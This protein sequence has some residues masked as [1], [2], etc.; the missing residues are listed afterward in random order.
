MT[1]NSGAT[2]YIDYK[3]EAL[4]MLDAK[5]ERVRQNMRSSSKQMITNLWAQLDLSSIYHDWALEGQVVSPE[6]LDLAFDARTITDA[7]NLPLNSSI[8]SHKETLNFASEVATRKKLVITSNL[9]REFHAFF[10]NDAESAK[11]A[12]EEVGVRKVELSARDEQILRAIVESH[13][14]SARPV[15]S[16]A[17][18]RRAALKVSS[19]TV[20]NTMRSLEDAGLIAQPHTSAGR[21]PTDLGYR[22]YVDNLIEPASPSG[23]H[24]AD[25]SMTGSGEA[26]I[27]A[28]RLR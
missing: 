8:R 15:S 7:T 21:V 6:E 18:L 17:V 5:A 25:V 3:S 16:S 27:R 22:Y 26:P 13:V 28:G 11:T 1:V 19:A 10:T 20:R 12:S 9:F 4:E 2:M 23:R 14:R 24:C